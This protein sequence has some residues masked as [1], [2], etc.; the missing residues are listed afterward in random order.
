MTKPIEIIDGAAPCLWRAPTLLK[1]MFPQLWVSVFSITGGHMNRAAYIFKT[2]FGTLHRR[3]SQMYLFSNVFGRVY[4]L[5]KNACVARNCVAS[6]QQR[7]VHKNF[8][9][10]QQPSVA[11]EAKVASSK[12]RKVADTKSKAVCKTKC[13]ATLKIF[14]L[15]EEYSP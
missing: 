3:V 8:C 13:N 4:R 1:P 12:S 15:T 7:A 6:K 9:G 11:Q 2:H 5:R 10:V 14:D